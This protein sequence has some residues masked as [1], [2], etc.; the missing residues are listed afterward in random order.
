MQQTFKR[1]RMREPDERKN[2]EK[3]FCAEKRQHRACCVQKVK[4]D[5]KDKGQMMRKNFLITIFVGVMLMLSAAAVFGATL[6][7]PTVTVTANGVS[8][9]LVSW[10]NVAGA[11]GYEVYRKTG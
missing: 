4:Q 1:Q 11:S 3:R 6:A 8:G 2:R 7:G 10:K 5:E 9:I